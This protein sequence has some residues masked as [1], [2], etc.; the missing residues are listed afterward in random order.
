MVTWASRPCLNRPKSKTVIPFSTNIHR[1]THGRDAHVTLTASKFRRITTTLAIIACALLTGCKHSP[2]QTKS[3][4]QPYAVTTSSGVQMLYIPGGSFSMGTSDGNADEAPP[5]QVSITPFL[6]D[7]YPVTHDLFVKAQLPDPSHWQDNPR[8]PVERVRW[9]DAKA[10]CNERSRLE[11]LKPCYNEKTTEWDCDYSADGYR[12]PTEAEW[13]YAARAGTEGPYDFGSAG[14]L[15]QY[16]WYA[17]NANK[18]THPVGQK[19]PNGWGLF[20]MYGNVSQ[21]C[22]DV[23]SPTYYKI[24]PPTDPPGPPGSGKDV[25]RVMRG[26]NWNASADACRVT[27]RRGE[28]TGNTDACF[29][30]DYCGF[31]CVRRPTAAEWGKMPKG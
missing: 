26:G 7:K 21:W 28:R 8:T 25:K 19:K 18:Q 10:Y 22:E 16:A 9:R 13:E 15:G 17:D 5:H 1:T 29:A 27:Y 6:M 31:R 4:A 11:G 30:T 24:S 3:A 20:D 2:S 14:Q 23:Y 12:L